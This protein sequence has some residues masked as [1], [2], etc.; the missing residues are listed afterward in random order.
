MGATMSEGAYA[1]AL[2]YGFL[3]SH[4]ELYSSWVKPFTQLRYSPQDKRLIATRVQ[5][6]YRRMS[7]WASVLPA[8]RSTCKFEL[9]VKPA[10]LSAPLTAHTQ[11]WAGDGTVIPRRYRATVFA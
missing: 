11:R 2:V 10:V 1:L 7:H 8:L 6:H 4:P 3:L 9:L 5:G